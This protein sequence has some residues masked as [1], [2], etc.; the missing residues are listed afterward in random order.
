MTITLIGQ[1]LFLVSVAVVALLLHRATRLELTLSCVLC[2]FL[3]GLSLPYIGFDTGV[4]ANNLHDVI[5]F[6]ILPVLI[7]EAGWSLRLRLLRR[8]LPP[9]LLLAT[10]G[11]LIS[12]FVTGWILYRGIDHAT[13]FPWIA[14]LLGGAILAATDPISVITQLKENHA[15]A[16]LTTLFEGES[17][18]NDASALVLFSLVL[19]VALSSDGGVGGTE[20]VGLFALTFFGGL[21]VGGLIGAITGLLARALVVSTAG[22]IIVLLA[23][24]ASFYVAEHLL[25]VSG[26]LA[27]MVAAM[28]TRQMMTRQNTEEVA[29]VDATWEW[30]ALIFNSLLFVL[31]G[32]V[33]TVEMFIDQWLAM[34]IAIVAALVGRAA[35]VIGCGILTQPM[36]NP[37]GLGWQLLL[38]WGGLRGAIAVALVLALPTELPYWYTIQCMVFG[39]VLFSLLVQGTT[40]GLLIKRFAE[41]R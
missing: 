4:R 21:A 34:L 24:F 40:N 29:V 33:I 12:T 26:I 23:A 5:F 16:D 32:L 41:P 20:A 22:P 30:L 25:H 37:I 35:S 27:V 17:L 36:P 13:G 15:P 10:V 8:W 39:V 6:V 2:G 9:I 18:F 19:G 1:M 3:A 14:A 7:F 31:M 38:F 28:V 11:I